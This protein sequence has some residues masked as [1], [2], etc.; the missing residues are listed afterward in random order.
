MCG[1]AAVSLWCRCHVTLPARWPLYPGC[2]RREWRRAVH[3]YLNELNVAHLPRHL[4]YPHGRAGSVTW[5]WQVVGVVVRVC[6]EGCGRLVAVVAVGESGEVAGPV[7]VDGGG[8]W[9]GRVSF[10]C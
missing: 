6:R 3:T 5:L 7:G 10:V 1:V 2:E 8:G 9:N 4:R